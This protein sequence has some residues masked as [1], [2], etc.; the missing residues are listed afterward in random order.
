M[1]VYMPHE[2]P[3]VEVLVDGVWYPGE[4]R[5]EWRRHGRRLC[6]VSWRPRV[7]LA[8]LDTVTADRVR[9]V[10]TSAAKVP[11]K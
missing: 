8:R 9:L 2:R 3:Q 5:G 7:G 6:N 10:G 4:L 11:A 1:K